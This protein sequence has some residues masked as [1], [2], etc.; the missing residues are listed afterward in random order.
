MKKGAII[1][2]QKYSTEYWNHQMDGDDGPVCLGY[3]NRIEVREIDTFRQYVH[4]ASKHQ[5][6]RACSRKQLLLRGRDDLDAEIQIR[7][8]T[9]ENHGKLP[10][11]SANPDDEYLLGCCSVFNVK[12]G[13]CRQ[14]AIKNDSCITRKD[15]AAELHT[16]IQAIQHNGNFRFAIMESLGAEDLC[17][18]ILANHYDHISNVIKVVQSFVCRKSLEKCKDHESGECGSC[19]IDNGHSVLMIDRSQKPEADIWG[20]TQASIHFSLRSV[21]GLHYLRSV[22]KLL[23]TSGVLLDGEQVTVDGCSGEYDAIMRCPARLLTEH[24]FGNGG[25][26]APGNSKYQSS[27]YQSETFVY[28]IGTSDAPRGSEL[29][30]VQEPSDSEDVLTEV[31]K[32]AVDELKKVFNYTTD[33]PDFDYIELPLWRLLKDYWSFASFPLNKELKEDLKIQ[34]IA[35]VNAIVAEAKKYTQRRQTDKFLESYDKIVDAL[36]SSMQAGSQQDRWYFGEQKSYIQNVESYY[37]IMHGYYGMIKDMIHL[38]YHIE[39]REG[40]EQPL[41]IPLLSFGVKTIIKSDSFSCTVNNKPAQLICIRLPYQALANLPRYLGPLAH[42]LFHYSAPAQRSVRNELMIK[43]LLRVAVTEFVSLLSQAQECEESGDFSKQFFSADKNYRGTFDLDAMV[44][45]IYSDLGRRLRKRNKEIGNLTLSE[46]RDFIL[47][48]WLNFPLSRADKEADTFYFQI[49]W[50]LR[51]MVEHHMGSPEEDVRDL[52]NHGVWKGI[53]DLKSERQNAEQESTEQ[54]KSEQ[55]NVKLN[56]QAITAKISVE[57]IQRF[58]KLL[59]NTFKA[60]EECPADIFD[61]EVVMA[62][63]DDAQKIQQYLWQINGARRDATLVRSFGND[64]L[65]EWPQ[66]DQRDGLLSNHIRIA[67]IL[68]YYLASQG[69]AS[70]SEVLEDWSPE[71]GNYKISLGRVKLGFIRDYQRVMGRFEGLLAENRMICNQ[72]AVRIR[73]L[74]SNDSCGRIMKRLTRMYEQYYTLLE[75][76]QRSQEKDP[77]TDY[78]EHLFDLCC[79]LI[80]AY[81]TQSPLDIQ[82]KTSVP[83]ESDSHTP[84]HGRAPLGYVARS[85]EDLSLCLTAALNW[86]KVRHEVPRLWFRGDSRKFRENL[87]DMTWQ[88]CADAQ[89]CNALRFGER[90]YPELVHATKAWTEATSD[91]PDRDA[92]V[93]VLNPCLFNLAMDL[94]E[95]A[96][97]AISNLKAYLKSKSLSLD[98]ECTNPGRYP[99]A[100]IPEHPPDSCCGLVCYSAEPCAEPTDYAYSLE[101]LQLQYQDKYRDL[102]NNPE[103]GEFFR[104]Q[105]C[106]PFLFRI[107][108]NHLHHV[109]FVTYL[110]AIGERC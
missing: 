80:D 50:N 88:M 31:V 49:W 87:P 89:P 36:R 73:H 62:E 9:P 19:I 8:S 45:Q 27:V 2:L 85:S 68:D 47:P 32:N 24:L 41:L 78:Q 23:N 10:F 20:T 84:D 22:E 30:L 6:N 39:R 51:R 54:D 75:Q 42:E 91:L 92:E 12:D 86:L 65:E 67:M 18:I 52:V 109:D 48:G 5:A 64:N 28:P 105:P 16:Q 82:S 81:Q 79:N 63:K 76:R 99:R 44:N 95:D 101:M 108:L 29:S 17:L 38:I 110:T 94:L 69:K 14:N 106:I 46:I 11:C 13:A 21:A 7:N 107:N 35:S 71:T 25:H 37:K 61:L 66:T 58:H 102:Q 60:M 56:Y 34:L 53:F 83:L 104:D 103:M 57:N 97:N 72:I 70:L 93:T 1:C 55:N 3:F 77:E 15:L 59:Y 33:D 4:E 90:F 43:V 40:E 26:F 74:L 100:I 96:Q 98:L